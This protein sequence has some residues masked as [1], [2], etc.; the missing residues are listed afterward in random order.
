MSSL[1]IVQNLRNSRNALPA[2]R[3]GR[4]KVDRTYKTNMK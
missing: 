3:R 2:G 4:E 1:L